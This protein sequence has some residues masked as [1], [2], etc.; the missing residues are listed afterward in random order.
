MQRGFS[1]HPGAA[2][3]MKKPRV[4]PALGHQLPPGVC[5]LLP[6]LM[7][8][9]AINWKPCQSQARHYLVISNQ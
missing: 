6:G 7:N 9:W 4:D 3:E 5:S 2:G 8:C 1:L